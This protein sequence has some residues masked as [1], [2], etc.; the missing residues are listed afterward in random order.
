MEKHE[1]GIARTKEKII[2]YGLGKEFQE[3][4]FFIESQYH[5]IGYSDKKEMKME[6]Y[7]RPDQIPESDY[8]YIYVASSKYLNEMKAELVEQYCVDKG[9]I[10]SKD[11]VLGDFQNAKVRQE[12]VVGR[13]KEIPEGKVLL[14]AGAGQMRY[15][16]ACKHLKYIAQDLGEYSSK[17]AEGGLHS[18]IESW[19]KWDVS[20]LNIVCDMIDMP[21]ENESIDVVLCSE[22]FEHLKN[23]VLAV[24]EFS[25]ILKP[26][27]KL[28]L[29][30]PVCCLSHMAPYFYYN[31][32]SEYW[33]REHL[34]DFGFEIEEFVS[35]GNFFQYISQ[36]L[37]RVNSMAG[38][39]CKTDL[40]EEE[41]KTITDSIKILSKLSAL[42][43]GS[44]ETL[45]FGNMLTAIKNNADKTES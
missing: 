43:Q 13:L 21:L 16:D 27:G 8:D 24:K 11:D 15:A 32:F 45:C 3:Q 23:P 26:G 28:I 42:D 5:V 7:I 39:Y 19:D 37:F 30:A 14:D 35:N 38:R 2:V 36:E 34:K 10:I 29:T 44:S 25:R 6:K 40:D 22:V 17:T 31:G 12:W 33:Y 1:A 9:H 20:R 4:R 41:I 18:N